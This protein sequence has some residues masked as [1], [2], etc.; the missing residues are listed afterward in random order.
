MER[1][2]TDSDGVVS[3]R[4]RNAV[5]GWGFIILGVALVAATITLVLWLGDFGG[6]V[7]ALLPLTAMFVY[8]G[9]QRLVRSGVEVLRSDKRAPVLYLRRF[10]DDHETFEPSVLHSRRR[11]ELSLGLPRTYEQK[12]AHALS[13]VGPFIA[14]GNPAEA[15]PELGAARIYLDD[16]KWKSTVSQLLA[17]SQLVVLHAGES[18]SVLWELGEILKTVDPL[19]VIISLPDRWDGP[20][21]ETARYD[22]FRD[23]TAHLFPRPLPA[24]S[25]EA[26][27]IYFDRNWNPFVLVPVKQQRLAVARPYKSV[28]EATLARALERLHREFLLVSS[29][30]GLRS[31]LFVPVASLAVLAMVGGGVRALLAIDDFAMGT[32]LFGLYPSTQALLEEHRPFIDKR[33]ED[34]RAIA[35]R[36]PP[37]GSAV[38]R[39]APVGLNPRPVYAPGAAVSNTE[40][41]MFEQLLDPTLASHPVLAF[42]SIEPLRLSMQWMA[43]SLSDTNGRA[44]DRQREQL[45]AAR[46]YRYVVVNRVIEYRAPKALTEKAFDPGA[47]TIEGFL[48]DLDSRSVLASYRTR[49]TSDRQRSYRAPPDRRGAL[50]K[51]ALTLLQLNA[52]NGVRQSLAECTDGQMLFEH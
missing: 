7:G 10:T 24:A 50:E 17:R 20:V 33:R 51:G 43:G 21:A 19:R 42:S 23:R 29:S 38:P 40:A 5:S 52:W 28:A 30:Y 11:L 3:Q 1:T 41:V 4:G 6:L 27:F 34:F 14:V 15:L 13:P 45:E 25:A 22:A 48:V 12:L 9:R 16:A 18:A 46:R 31:V 49:A 8:I 26:R 2:P 32:T 39:A 37:L 36:L 47:V 44:T 35:E